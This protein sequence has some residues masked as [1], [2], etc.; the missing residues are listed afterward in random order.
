MNWDFLAVKIFVLGTRYTG[1]S[2]VYRDSNWCI[3]I[4]CFGVLEFFFLCIA[5]VGN[6]CGGSQPTS[7]AELSLT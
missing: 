7:S 4:F 3:E 6:Q 1:I 2:L 5:L